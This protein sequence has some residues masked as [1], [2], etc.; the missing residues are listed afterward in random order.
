[1]PTCISAGDDNYDSMD[2]DGNC[3]MELVFLCRQYLIY[4]IIIL[5]YYHLLYNYVGCIANSAFIAFS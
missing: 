1:M 3:S 4:Y 2:S 5:L